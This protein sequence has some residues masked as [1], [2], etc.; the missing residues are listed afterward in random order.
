MFMQ[1]GNS[2][3]CSGWS[4]KGMANAWQR[5]K[6]PVYMA[7]ESIDDQETPV[8]PLFPFSAVTR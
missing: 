7:G 6:V 5:D 1:V 2:W 3:L 8:C 4:D